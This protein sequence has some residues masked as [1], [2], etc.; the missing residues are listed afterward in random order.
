[1]IPPVLLKIK[2]LALRNPLCLVFE[3]PG[4]RHK[5]CL[6]VKVDHLPE[7]VVPRAANDEVKGVKIINSREQSPLVIGGVYQFEGQLMTVI[8]YETACYRCV[9]KEEPEEGTYPTTK[10]GGIMGTT[11]G[12]FGI[13]EAN[14]AVKYIVFEDK[15]KLLANRML[16]ADLLYNSFE[17]FQVEKDDSCQI[18]S[19]MK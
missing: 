1:M 17:L 4:D 11:A 5:Y 8:P 10:T 9:F 6:L 12:L 7:G 13:I 15:D 19:Q 3:Q 16:H 2:L 18:C 14:E